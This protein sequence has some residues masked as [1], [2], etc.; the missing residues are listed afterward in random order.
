ML[1]L[2]SNAGTGNKIL[3]NWEFFKYSLKE[4]FKTQESISYIFDVKFGNQKGRMAVVIKNGIITEDTFLLLEGFEKT[5]GAYNDT[6]DFS[7]GLYA[8]GRKMLN[9]IGKI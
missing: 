1:K 2:K 6:V 3:K 4:E 5:L 9:E 7:S 8:V